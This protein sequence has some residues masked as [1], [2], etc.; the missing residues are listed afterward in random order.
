LSTHQH[1]I[2]RWSG[3]RAT[4]YSL[5]W[6][7]PV[8]NRVVVEYAG[9]G[10]G[11][12]VL[13]IGCGPGAAL[14]SASRLGAD[15]YGVDPS[16]SMVARAGRRVPDATVVEG[17][18]E[19]LPFP[20]GA[21]SHVL[22]ISTFHHWASQEAGIDEVHR[23]LTPGGRFFNVERKLEPDNDGHGLDLSA[24]EGLSKTLADHGFHD[25]SVG[26]VR[27]KRVEY[28]VVSGLA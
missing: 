6:R 15:V 13:D 3:L 9:V 11:D 27:A 20:D 22:A 17:S 18:A 24:A 16:P 5:I 21:F 28:V 7:N 14:E 1:D 19:S 12:R 10:P 4:L 26:T 8:S 23:A 25:C 2:E